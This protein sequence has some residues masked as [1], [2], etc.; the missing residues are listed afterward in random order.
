MW[1]GI[2]ISVLCVLILFGMFYMLYAGSK[3]LVKSN[4]DIA[5]DQLKTVNE[6][7][8]KIV[9]AIEATSRVELEA[10]EG[11][12][13]YMSAVADATFGKSSIKIEWDQECIFE[14]L[15]EAL[16]LSGFTLIPE[17]LQIHSTGVRGVYRLENEAG[18]CIYMYGSIYGYTR[19]MLTTKFPEGL[20]LGITPSFEGG[21]IKFVE[22]TDKVN[23][24]IISDLTF[25]Y[26]ANE[27]IKFEYINEA[28]RKASVFIEYKD[29]PKDNKIYKIIQFGGQF[30][31]QESKLMNHF[32]V[33]EH[34]DT[35]Y[36]STRVVNPAT[37]E[38]LDVYTSKLF[39]GLLATWQIE[40]NENPNMRTHLALGRDTGTGK[41]FLSAALVKELTKLTNTCVFYASPEILHKFGQPEFETYAPSLF[42]S[43]FANFIVFD[44]AEEVL[45]K[46]AALIKALTSGQ[47]AQEFNLYFIICYNSDKED[48]EFQ[49]SLFRA[50]RFLRIELGNFK[51][52]QQV[53]AAVKVL[54][55]IHY[56]KNM[57]RPLDTDTTNTVLT[58]I[59]NNKV[60][61]LSTLFGLFRPQPT[62]DMFHTKVNE[63]VKNEP[64]KVIVNT[65]KAPQ[66]NKKRNKRR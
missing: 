41:T 65:N 31:Q 66:T 48:E 35:L 30:R 2:L 36:P 14:V 56:K 60:V 33:R 57:S 47:L 43:K 61:N 53:E 50:G 1:T 29:K 21:L 38:W 62:I 23:V 27:E 28:L 59:E 39:S 34:L 40:I 7:T 3:M 20:T 26:S 32:D 18:N 52:R 45:K 12:K 13:T 9:E 55:D 11:F 17:K 51:T 54:T 6:A 63:L 64:T 22:L 24:P 15:T 4:N 8:K 46:D 58:L 10:K 42:S 16:K 25:V 37:D 49:E 5:N 19:K 44:E